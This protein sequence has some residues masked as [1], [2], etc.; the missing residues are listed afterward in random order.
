[1]SSLFTKFGSNTLG[2]SKFAVFG[3]S[4]GAYGQDFFVFGG[5]VPVSG[6]DFDFFRRLGPTVS[7]Q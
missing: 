3:R 6:A 4:I 7:I 1:M 2:L 5:Q